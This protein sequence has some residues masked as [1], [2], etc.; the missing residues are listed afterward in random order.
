MRKYKETP[1]IGQHWGSA[2]LGWV[3]GWPSRNT[4]LPMFA[5]L[6]N[7]VV[8]GQMARALLRRSI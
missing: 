5:I 3:H 7:L 8:L 2:P 6:P 4:P 1:K